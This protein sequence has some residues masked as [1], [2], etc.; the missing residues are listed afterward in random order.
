MESKLSGFIKTMLYR[1][2]SG[3]LWF[4]IESLQREVKLQSMVSGGIQQVTSSVPAFKSP[5]SFPFFIFIF[6]LKN[7]FFLLMVAPVAYA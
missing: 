6:S 3:G 5:I 2:W 1:M 4:F 7:F